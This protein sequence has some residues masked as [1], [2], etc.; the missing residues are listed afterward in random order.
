MFRAGSGK[1]HESWLH[2]KDDGYWQT[3]C[4]G[5]PVHGKTAVD[6]TVVF[7]LTTEEPRNNVEIRQN[8]V[9]EPGVGTCRVVQFEREAKLLCS[10]AV[11]PPA[12]GTVQMSDI[13]YFPHSWAPLGVLPG[14]SPVFKWFCLPD[15]G[16][17]VAPALNGAFVDLSFVKRRPIAFLKRTY[18]A[19]DVETGVF[20]K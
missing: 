5:E 7:A 11:R 18:T 19:R 8:T 16:E 17:Y 14:F 6:L 15:H 10:A 13:S 12:R 1:L 9:T 4:A 3:A 20:G 2:R